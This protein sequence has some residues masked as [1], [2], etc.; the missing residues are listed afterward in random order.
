MTDSTQAK[1][2]LIDMSAFKAK[3]IEKNGRG[4]RGKYPWD[5]MKIDDCF[6]VSNDQS[7]I[8]SVR[9]MASAKGRDLGKRF[10]VTIGTDGSW[11][12]REA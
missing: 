2:P 7:R 9:S 10:S 6:F 4:R 12:T 3:L 8:S 5:T 11:V 1:R